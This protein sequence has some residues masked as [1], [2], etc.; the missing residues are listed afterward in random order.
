MVG[1]DGLVDE[2]HVVGVEMIVVVAEERGQFGEVDGVVVF[3]FVRSE[4][5]LVHEGIG[6][7]EEVF[8]ANEIT[9]SLFL[10]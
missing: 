5:N 8:Y 7:G 2:V 1:E 3:G 10:V 6:L 9:F 4:L